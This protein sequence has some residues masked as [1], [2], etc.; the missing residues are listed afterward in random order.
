MVKQKIAKYCI[1][2][3]RTQSQT[4][5]LIKTQEN[6]SDLVMIGFSFASVL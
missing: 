2:P 6:T 1:E 5:K 4:N 3:M